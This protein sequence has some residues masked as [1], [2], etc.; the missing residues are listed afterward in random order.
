MQM[1]KKGSRKKMKNPNRS[2]IIALACCVL[3]LVSAL[4]SGGFAKYTTQV[5]S[6]GE[7]LPFKAQLFDESQGGEFKL[8]ELEGTMEADGAQNNMG[9]DTVLANTYYMIPGTQ[10]YKYPYISYQHKTDIPAYLYLVVEGSEPVDGEFTYG[11]PESW[12]KIDGATT[13]AGAYVLLDTDT[14]GSVKDTPMVLNKDVETVAAIV[15]LDFG[16]ADKWVN[17]LKLQKMTENKEISFTAYAIQ[18]P[19]PKATVADATSVWNTNKNGSDKILIDSTAKVTNTFTPGSVTASIVENGEPVEGE[20]SVSAKNSITVKNAG[21]VPALVRA[22]LV[23]NWIKLGEDGK[24]VRD[25]AGTPIIIAN[26]VGT[27]GNPL[28][29]TPSYSSDW[30][31]NLGDGYCYYNDYVAAGATTTDLLAAAITAPTNTPAGY[32]MQVEVIT[33][34]MQATGYNDPRNPVDGTGTDANSAM[35]L[36]W[37]HFFNG[38]TWQ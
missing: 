12:K 27:D 4:I 38:S 19:A 16:A 33:E 15:T 11:I 2:R 28:T 35:Y 37:N 13:V 5:Q 1:E 31:T 20:T 9:D 3:L 29:I 10:I 21:N 14:D 25:E 23:V 17:I 26:P 18:A 34:A 7:G 30:T 36:A 32:A 24:P 22:K 6:S 8:E